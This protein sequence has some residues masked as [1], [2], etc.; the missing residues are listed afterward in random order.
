MVIYSIAEK[1]TWY[2]K[3]TMRKNPLSTESLVFG[4]QPQ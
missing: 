3:S 4:P 2:G 1:Y